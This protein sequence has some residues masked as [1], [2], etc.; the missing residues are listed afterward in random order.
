MDIVAVFTH[1]H[2]P[3]VP[4]H[5]IIIRKL[6]SVRLQ[7]TIPGESFMYWFRASGYSGNDVGVAHSSP[8]YFFRESLETWLHIWLG[9]PE[10]LLQQ[11]LLAMVLR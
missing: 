5:K 8:N 2:T 7:R 1:T 4:L 3:S 10:Q 9:L 11:A 6:I